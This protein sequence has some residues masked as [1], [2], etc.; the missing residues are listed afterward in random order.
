MPWGIQKVIFGYNDLHVRFWPAGQFAPSRFWPAGTCM[1]DWITSQHKFHT[2]DNT[3]AGPD[4]PQS[5]VTGSA[6]AASFT[7]SVADISLKSPQPKQAPQSPQPIHTPRAARAAACKM[8]P[9]AKAAVKNDHNNV[10]QHALGSDKHAD[11]VGAA[12]ATTCIMPNKAKAAV[13]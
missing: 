3:Y 9:N 5:K 10:F 1:Q 8:P 4:E 13:K 11:P 6:C 12:C 2:F 7:A